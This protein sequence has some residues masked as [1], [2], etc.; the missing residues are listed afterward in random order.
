[1]LRSLILR[2][3]ITNCGINALGLA[4]SILLSH[5][6]GPVGRGEIAAAMLWPMLLAYLSSM[7]IISSTSYFAAARGS[8]LQSIFSNVMALALI[9]SAVALVIGYLALPYLLHS[10][11]ANV[12]NTARLYLLVIPIT[13]TTQYGT[14]ILQGRMHMSAFNWLR[15]II[16]FGYLAGTVALA[17]TG[18]L[19]L[20]NIVI[21][22]LG[23]AVAMWFGAMAVL[24]RLGIRPGFRPDVGLGKDMLR[25]GA[26][27][28]V[29][30]VSGQANQSLDQVLM[31][32]WLPPAYLG[33]Y[34]VA[35]SSAA[36]SQLFS[37]SVKMAATP[38]IAQRESRSE[39]AAVLQGVFRRYW[40]LSFLIALAISAF[41]PIAIPVV[42]GIRFKAAIW[43]AEVLLVGTFLAGAMEVLA[44]GAQALGDPW[45]GSRAQLGALAVTVLLLYLLLPRM[46]IMGAA[47]ATTAACA[48]QLLIVVAGLRSSHAIPAMSL[49][50]LRAGDL[51][52]AFRIFD[53]F[54]A[55]RERLLPDQG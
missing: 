47:I 55:K 52:S 34:V 28:Q 36:L 38:S 8:K 31:A 4:N 14:S 19:V 24:L 16:P 39:R 37:G 51:G 9:Q 45:L 35:V 50:R 1:M 17:M 32:A 12:I 29:G 44:G 54:R 15:T 46:G 6:L 40:L 20:L 53:I 10:Q 43:P 18:R 48:T 21:L 26:K 7:G 13:L 2:T 49:F 3:L 30:S 27:V 42:F 22:H 5:W 23:L 11:S 25:Y 41:L 33:L